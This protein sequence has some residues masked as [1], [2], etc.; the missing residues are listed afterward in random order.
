M[1]GAYGSILAPDFRA[2]HVAL[3]RG[4]GAKHV[5]DS[6]SASFQ[7]ELTDALADTG[8]TLAFDA[9]GGGTLAAQI[10]TCMERAA[11]RSLEGHQG[12]GSSTH[13]QVYVYG[14]LDTS[15]TVLERSFG[16]AWGIGGWLLIP[17]LAKIGMEGGMKLQQRVVAELETTFASTYSHTISL[18]EALQPDT[19]H[20]YRRKATGDKY[21]IDPSR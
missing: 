8:A 9:I 13:K 7:D 10:L 12:Y 3:L 20:A 16:M 11:L 5:C 1:Y 21:L 2:E 19:V 15:P 18:V 6:T 14:G 4:L 17:F